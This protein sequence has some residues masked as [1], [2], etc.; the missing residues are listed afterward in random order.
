MNVLTVVAYGA[1]AGAVVM[2]IT[3]I[4]VPRLRS[5]LLWVAAGMFTV[6]GVLGILSI[7]IL[8]LAAA[9]VC[10]WM[11]ARAAVRPNTQP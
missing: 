10:A 7:G 11:A 2:V 4:V 1:M 5:P 3:A 8:F 6:V 9:V